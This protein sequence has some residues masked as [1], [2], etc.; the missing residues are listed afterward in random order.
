MASP[1]AVPLNDVINE[2]LED[3]VKVRQ[4]DS[5]LT[6]T[7]KGVVADLVWEAHKKEVKK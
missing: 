4:V 5:H 6:V 2:K 3:I 1:K 7:K